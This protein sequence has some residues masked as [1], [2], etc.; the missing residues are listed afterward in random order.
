MVYNALQGRVGGI[1]HALKTVSHLCGNL[2][3]I[4][5]RRLAVGIL[6]FQNAGL[7]K[8]KSKAVLSKEVDLWQTSSILI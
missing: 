6:L 2:I 1:L 7:A 4:T 8:I 3:T 5:A